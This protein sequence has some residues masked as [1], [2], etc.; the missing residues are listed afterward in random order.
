VL[1]LARFSSAVKL[2]GVQAF[3]SAENALA[4]INDVSEG[5]LSADLKTFLE[6]SLPASRK[7]RRATARPASERAS[8]SERSAP[9]VRHALR[10]AA[11]RRVPPRRPLA[12]PLPPLQSSTKTPTWSL[13]VADPRLGSA[14]QEGCGI[15]CHV[16]D[17]CVRRRAAPAAAAAPRLTAASLTLSLAR[18]PAPLPFPAQRVRAA[19]RRAAAH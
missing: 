8:A 4:N 15:P 16:S 3:T 5:A 1:D 18:C 11:P 6:R 14:I 9:G 10:R 2:R 19:A 12:I 7:V 13:G 17:T